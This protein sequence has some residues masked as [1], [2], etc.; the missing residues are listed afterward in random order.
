MAE[1][2]H[3]IDHKLDQ[4]ISHPRQIAHSYASSWS[5]HDSRDGNAPCHFSKISGISTENKIFKLQRIK[6]TGFIMNI[7]IYLWHFKTYTCTSWLERFFFF[8]LRNNISQSVY[9]THTFS[10][11]IVIKL[12]S[13]TIFKGNISKKQGRKWELFNGM[14][15]KTL[16]KSRKCLIVN[17]SNK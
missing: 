12:R 15:K 14:K 2:R 8:L 16:H 4:H 10:W 5:K 9:F 13:S 3:F 11:N 6:Q 17:F 1:R 7:K